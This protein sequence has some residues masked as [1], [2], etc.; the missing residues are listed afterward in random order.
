MHKPDAW[1]A[2]DGAGDV[3]LDATNADFETLAVLIAPVLPMPASK[4]NVLH[5]TPIAIG[6]PQDKSCKS[7]KATRANRPG[8]GRGIISASGYVQHGQ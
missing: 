8:Y 2:D 4:P 6:S 3:D 1:D 7:T 5:V